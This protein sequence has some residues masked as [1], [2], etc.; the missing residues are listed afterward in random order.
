MTEFIEK[1]DFF[2]GCRILSRCGKGSF[3]VTY[4]AENPI[5]RMIAI[6]IVASAPGSYERELR[7]LQNYMQVSG[8]HPNLLQIFHIGE[9][10]DHFYY[11]MEAADNCSTVPGEYLPATLGNLMRQ[12]KKFSPEE[13]VSITR[14]LLAGIGRMHDAGLLHRD[15]KPENIFK[16]DRCTF[17]NEELFFSHRRDKG[18]TGVMAAIISPKV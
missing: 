5:G 18:D 2:S 16:D 14:Q 4:L 13:A 7:G 8:T 3:G 11:I 6:K 12:G 1:G 10:G 9:S 15:I 17:E